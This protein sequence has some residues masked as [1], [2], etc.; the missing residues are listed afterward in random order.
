MDELIDA[1]KTLNDDVS[2][3]ETTEYQSPD[4]A[5]DFIKKVEET[6]IKEEKTEEKPLEFDK[7]IPGNKTSEN[8]SES[9][10]GSFMSFDDIIEASE[11]GQNPT[12]EKP[13][14]PLDIDDDEPGK[15]QDQPKEEEKPEDTKAKRDARTVVGESVFMLS[16]S[17]VRLIATAIAGN[18]ASTSDFT[19]A[20]SDEKQLK[21]AWTDLAM[22]YDWEKPPAWITIVIISAAAYHGVFRD[23]L[24]IRKVNNKKKE[25]I[26][27]FKDTKTNEKTPENTSKKIN[28]KPADIPAKEGRGRRPKNEEKLVKI[29]EEQNAKIKELNQAM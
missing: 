15:T 24:K 23:A 28:L 27:R 4:I 17:A 3:N 16:D 21:K 7:E 22:L 14:V 19:I 29:I 18:G 26:K 13:D 9:E 25:Q 20:K 5:K 8:N 2:K 10:Q 11:K 12:E 6:E 1:N